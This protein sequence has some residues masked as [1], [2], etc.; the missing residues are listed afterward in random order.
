M[1]APNAYCEQNRCVCTNGYLGDGY[2]CDLFTQIHD[3]RVSID[4][5]VYNEYRRAHC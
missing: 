4:V 5:S 2:T 3:K 1:C